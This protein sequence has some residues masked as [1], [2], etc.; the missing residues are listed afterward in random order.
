VPTAG[1]STRYTL[2]G[3]RSS[4]RGYR[5]VSAGIRSPWTMKSETSRRSR[6]ARRRASSGSR[7]TSTAPAAPPGSAPSGRSTPRR[8]SS[9][10][11]A[12]PPE[13]CPRN[14]SAGNRSAGGR[15]LESKGGVVE[16]PRVV[17]R[18][19][20]GRS[21]DQ[22]SARDA[23]EAVPSGVRPGDVRRMPEGP[24]VEREGDDTQSDVGEVER[25]DRPHQ[26]EDALGDPLQHVRARDVGGRG[27]V[28]VE[29]H[30]DQIRYGDG[31]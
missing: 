22:E 29:T 9:S 6:A 1:P 4:P 20:R 31:G 3:S 10:G 15:R 28:G 18:Q 30:V 8:R 7:S 21:D 11:F 13:S 23:P 19:A 26:D 14:T 12:R 25:V 24:G 16:D 17:E 2:P 5:D 27:H